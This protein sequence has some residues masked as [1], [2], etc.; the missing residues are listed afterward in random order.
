MEL[1]ENMCKID[2]HQTKTRDNR[3]S[4]YQQGLTSIL[5]WK[6]N[7]MGWNYL[8]IPK[9][10]RLYRWRLGM[11]KLFHPI[12]YNG[13][14]Y[15]RMLGL[16]TCAYILRHAVLLYYRKAVTENL[17]IFSQTQE[18]ERIDI[19]A[20]TAALWQTSFNLLQ[21]SKV[22]WRNKSGSPLAQVMVCFLPLPVHFFRKF[23]WIHLISC[24][25]LI[26]YTH[27]KCFEARNRE[28]TMDQNYDDV[29]K[30]KYFPLALC[31]GNSPVTD[32]FP[33]QRPVSRSFDAFFDLRLNKRLRKQ[34]QCRWFEALIM[35]SL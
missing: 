13:Y 23:Y 3:G 24:S 27:G 2:C 22:I 14:N 9:Y 34:P 16:K 11:D 7:H 21:A 20:L 18:A 26:T 5:P 15:L 12:L 33:T 6:N 29:I 35:T 19:I 4:F 28:V 8:S 30:W 32:E 17:M 31:A 10:Q 1:L 25:V